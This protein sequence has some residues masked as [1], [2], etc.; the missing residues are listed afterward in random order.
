MVNKPKAR[1]P[2]ISERGSRQQ[3][4]TLDFDNAATIDALDELGYGIE[5]LSLRTLEEFLHDEAHA[6]HEM[7]VT[8]HA[9]RELQHKVANTKF[10]RYEKVRKRK[11]A[12]VQ[13]QMRIG[14]QFNRHESRAMSLARQDAPAVVGGASALIERKRL[15]SIM[16]RQQKERAKELAAQKEQER[17]EQKMKEKEERDKKLQEER[18]KVKRKEREAEEAWKRKALLDRQNREQAKEKVRLE[19]KQ[20]AVEKKARMEQ[21]L[22]RK[23][24]DDKVRRT[25]EARS[26]KRK[27]MMRQWLRAKNLALRE[28]RYDKT[29][30]RMEWTERTLFLRMQ[31]KKEKK[32]QE[33]LAERDRANARIAAALVT[34]EKVRLRRIRQFNTKKRVAEERKEVWMAKRDEELQKRG[35]EGEAKRQQALANKEKAEQLAE[36]RIDGFERKREAQEEQFRAECWHREMERLAKNAGLHMAEELSQSNV[37]RI[38][39]LDVR[40]C[41]RLSEAI[42]VGDAHTAHIRALKEEVAK[43]L[44][45]ERAK[46]FNRKHEMRSGVQRMHRMQ[47]MQS[48]STSRIP[49]RP[50]GPSPSSTRKRPDSARF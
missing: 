15:E 6:F 23:F 29:R 49:H 45:E 5:E 7:L 10:E 14:K 43:Q 28:E 33:L 37:R 39:L 40:A 11:V 25:K 3:L 1:S 34:A 27:Q 21:E 32:K 50:N 16:R 38:R 13:N 19:E 36:K 12:H 44:Q 26:R 47:R 18:E 46:S 17:K 35:A 20:K 2:V 48:T 31:A 8:Q 24:K 22:R 4:Y 41:K 9:R 30:L 42:D